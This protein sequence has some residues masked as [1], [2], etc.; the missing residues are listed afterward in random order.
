MRTAGSAP[1][2]TTTRSRYQLAEHVQGVRNLLALRPALRPLEPL[3]ELALRLGAGRS[4]LRRLPHLRSPRVSEVGDL[5]GGPNRVEPGLEVDGAGQLDHRRAPGAWLF[6]EQAL[7]PV[8]PPGCDARCQLQLTPREPTGGEV[9]LDR[10]LR[11]PPEAHRLAPRAE[12]L[13]Q[14]AELIGD[15]DDDGVVRRLLEILEERIG[16]VLVHRVRTEDEVDAP[17]GFERTHV[18][19]T[20][21]LADGI[22][23]NLVAERLED[24]EV[25]VRPPD[26]PI[27]VSD[28]GAREEKGRAA[29]PRSGRPV[30]QVGVSR[31]FDEGRS[32]EALRVLLFRQGLE[33]VHVPPSRCRSQAWSHRW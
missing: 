20:A 31:P 15:E 25:W 3:L 12:R 10:A 14:R 21:H 24:V 13:G 29:L 11:E 27:G 7:G 8:E 18:Q 5:L 2:A 32:Q 22:D 16:G 17:V 28:Q 9:R 26:D 4:L 6:G 19:V 1:A 30:E 23:P 33:A